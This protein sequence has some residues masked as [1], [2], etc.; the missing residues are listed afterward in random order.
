[1]YA[2][3][4]ALITLSAIL[5]NCQAH[6]AGSLDFSQNEQA[7]FKEQDLKAPLDKTWLEKYGPQIDFPFSGPLSFS[8]LPYFRCLENEHES[9]DIAILGMPF[10]TA[11]TYRPGYMISLHRQKAIRDSS[12]PY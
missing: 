6:R 5:L 3:L 1:M 11:V 10:D 2:K 9:F 12:L 8:H 4:G 7:L